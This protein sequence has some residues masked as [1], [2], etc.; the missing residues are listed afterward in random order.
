M[1]DRVYVYVDGES[2]YIRSEV[3]WRKLHGPGAR[4]DRLRYA[5]TAGDGLVLIEPKAKVFWTRRL[6]P[7]VQRTYYFTS[8]VGDHPAL[9]ELRKT[10]RNFGL[11]PSI[12]SE[13][14][15]LA[16]QRQNLLQTEGVIEK[17]KCVDIALAVRMLED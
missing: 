7:G 2:H 1:D 17:A 9:H 16:K 12:F 15:Q 8:F 13:R 11:E 6:S 5:A 14:N 4:L 10:L 3:A